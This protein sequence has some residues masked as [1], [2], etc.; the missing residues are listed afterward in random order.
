MTTCRECGHVGGPAA[1]FCTRCGGAVPQAPAGV[2]PSVASFQPRPVP[3]FAARPTPPPPRRQSMAGILTVGGVALAVVVAV[4]VVAVVDNMSTTTGGASAGQPY[5]PPAVTQQV[6]ADGGYEQPAPTYSSPAPTYSSPAPTDP[7]SAKAEL[8]RLV[9]ADRATV[10]SLVGQ[11]V[12]QL[13][14]KRPGLVANGITYDYVTILADYRANQARYPDAK[15]L[16]SGEYT[17]FKFA[18]FWITIVPQPYSDGPS[19]NTWCDAA[20]IPPDDCY[21]KM[22]SHS[23]GYDGATLLRNR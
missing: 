9:A 10:E 4:A 13:S 6:P 21:A 18:D 16:F 12:P 23:Q 3:T 15:L 22:I 1:R 14:A 19:A 7:S 11:W 5:T 8:D 2:A 20:A 17:S